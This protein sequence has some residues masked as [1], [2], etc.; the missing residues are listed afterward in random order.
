MLKGAGGLRPPA[1]LYAGRRHLS[2]AVK[3][4]ASIQVARGSLRHLP[5]IPKMIPMFETR[6]Y[7]KLRNGRQKCANWAPPFQGTEVASHSRGKLSDVA[8][9]T[10]RFGGVRAH[11]LLLLLEPTGVL[12][13]EPPFWTSLGE[14]GQIWMSLDESG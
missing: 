13:A 5:G 14:S 1:P 10:R 4:D 7:G 2:A 3:V 11:C 9:Q 6:T 12:H 8:S